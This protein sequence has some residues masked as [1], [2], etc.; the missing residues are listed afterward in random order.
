MG[1]RVQETDI[2]KFN[3]RTLKTDTKRYLLL[4]KARNYSTRIDDF[5]KKTSVYE[6]IKGACI[7][8]LL[9]VCKNPE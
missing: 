8:N 5:G 6:L 1:Y 2:V 9:P 4:N 7:E 3:G